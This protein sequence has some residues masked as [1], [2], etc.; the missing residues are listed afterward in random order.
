LKAKPFYRYPKFGRWLA[1]LSPRDEL[2]TR[3][4]LRDEIRQ[5]GVGRKWDTRIAQ[6]TTELINNSDDIVDLSADVMRA[7]SRLAEIIEAGLK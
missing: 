4:A 2:V 1:S 7:K 5:R 3:M 6:L